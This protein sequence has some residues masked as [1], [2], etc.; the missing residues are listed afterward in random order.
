MKKCIGL[1]VVIL[2]LWA[3]SAFAEIQLLDNG[4]NLGIVAKIDVLGMSVTRDGLT[5]YINGQSNL[6]LAGIANGGATSMTSTTYAVPTAYGYVGIHLGPNIGQ[7]YTLANGKQG[8]ILTLNIYQIDGSGTMILTPT[9][10]TGF[11][12]LTFDA[13]DDRATL[14][15]LNTTD[16]WIL[17]SGTSVTVGH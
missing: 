5:G 2:C 6:I 13:V 14:L 12:T 11:T 9:T 8:Q 16:G 10:K 7:A 1:F 4:T 3:T 17:L 15:F